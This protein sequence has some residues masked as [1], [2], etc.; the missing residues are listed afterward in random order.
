MPVN[1]LKLHLHNKQT[2]TIKSNID[3]ICPLHLG[4]KVVFFEF[5]EFRLLWHYVNLPFLI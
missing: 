1:Q 2:I 4:S 5:A 3:I